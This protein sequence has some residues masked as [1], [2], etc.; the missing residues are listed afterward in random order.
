MVL[1]N[2]SDE[3]YERIRSLVSMDRASDVVTTLLNLHVI[4]DE[5][6]LLRQQIGQ[7]ASDSMNPEHMDESNGDINMGMVLDGIEFESSAS[8]SLSSSLKESKASKSIEADHDSDAT[9][10]I[11]EIHGQSL[12]VFYFDGIVSYDMI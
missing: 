7:L 11:R 9:R 4:E 2:I 10:K 6:S 1:S 8:S 5:Q 3:I 12:Q